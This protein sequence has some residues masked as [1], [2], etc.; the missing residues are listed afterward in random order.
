MKTLALAALLLAA[1]AAPAFAFNPQP[2]PP[3]KQTNTVACSNNMHA[4]TNAATNNAQGAMHAN[5]NVQANRMAM[6]AHVNGDGHSAL[7]GNLHCNKAP[8][9]SAPAAH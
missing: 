7:L 1:T 8:T 2:D 6:N 3:G 4:N 9:T 5:A